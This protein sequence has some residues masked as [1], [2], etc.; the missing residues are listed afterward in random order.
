MGSSHQG[1][2]AFQ[3]SLTSLQQRE[4]PDFS[5]HPTHPTPVLHVTPLLGGRYV[6]PKCLHLSKLQL[7]SQAQLKS[8]LLHKIPKRSCPQ[9]FLS[10]NFSLPL[11]LQT[12]SVHLNAPVLA[13]LSFPI[14]RRICIDT[15]TSIYIFKCIYFP[16]VTVIGKNKSDSILDLFLLLSPLYCIAFASSL[17]CCPG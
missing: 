4:R 14:Q 3:D 11:S 5:P 17:K 12:S 10:Q 8:N 2:P 6:L 13:L 7:S 16:N 15:Y 9:G 1:L